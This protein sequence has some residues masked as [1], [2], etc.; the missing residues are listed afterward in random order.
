MH[1]IN[2]YKKLVHNI[3]AMIE[4]SGYR[5]DYISRKLNITPQRFSLK[6]RNESWSVDEVEKLL[7]IIMNEDIEDFLLA[8]EMESIKERGYDLVDT[9]E[10]KSYFN[11]S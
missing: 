9:D 3:P 6:K 10:V 1:V 11:E 2:Q 4:L 5:N 7:N 8:L